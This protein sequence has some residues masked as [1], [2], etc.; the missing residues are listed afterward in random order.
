MTARTPAWL[1]RKLRKN[2]Y[3]LPAWWHTTITLALLR[4]A[5]CHGQLLR[6]A[7]CHGQLLRVAA[8]HGQLLRVQ[9]RG[10]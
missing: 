1:P 6:V 7:F 8:C 2:P 9:G 3:F 4:V 5:A 10:I